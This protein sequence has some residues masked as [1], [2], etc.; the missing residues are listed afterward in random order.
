MANDSVV[1]IPDAV[2]RNSKETLDTVT[3]TAQIDEVF[4]R[5]RHEDSTLRL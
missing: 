3:W 4:R 1:K 2:N 5:N